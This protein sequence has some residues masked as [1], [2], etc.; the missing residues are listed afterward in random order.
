[1]AE[2]VLTLRELNRAGLDASAARARLEAANGAVRR[3]LE[4]DPA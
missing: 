3:A 4:Q 1:V 2:R